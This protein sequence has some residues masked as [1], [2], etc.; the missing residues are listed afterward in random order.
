MNLRI[1]LFA[2]VFVVAGCAT[3]P[4]PPSAAAL[5]GDP[6]HPGAAAGWVRTELYFGIALVDDP[7]PSRTEEK[8]RA[9]LD[10]EVTPRFPDGL[11]VF[12]IYGQWRSKGHAQPVRQRSKVI[13]VLYPDTPQHRADIDAVRAAWK[14]DTGDQSVLKVTQAAEVSF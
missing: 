4:A 1:A 8:W 11:S 3:A 6:A 10:S 12:D 14:R 13:V 5:S 2:L 7:N 9:F